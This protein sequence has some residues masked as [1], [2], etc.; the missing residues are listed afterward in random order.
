MVTGFSKGIRPRTKRRGLAAFNKNGG[1]AYYSLYAKEAG[2]KICGRGFAMTLRNLIIV[3]A[4]AIAASG[5]SS[6][7]SAQFLENTDMPGRDYRSFDING[8]ASR[9]RESCL[10]E[11]KCEA[12][13]WVRRGVQGPNARCWLKDAVP[14]AVASQ[15]CT[16]GTRA[17]K[18]D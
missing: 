13:T 10:A 8:G 16:S 3:A 1:G 11:R 2:P 18:I 9:C 7:A 12:W 4:F 6:N 5:I 17:V 15:C 14:R